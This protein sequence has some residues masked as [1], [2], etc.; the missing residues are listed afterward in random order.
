MF[1]NRLIRETGGVA[2]QDPN[3][4]TDLVNFIHNCTM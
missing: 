2:F 4:R 1:G 3:F